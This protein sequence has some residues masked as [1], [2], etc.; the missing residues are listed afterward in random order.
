M[1][2]VEV[3]GVA[4]LCFQEP[5]AFKVQELQAPGWTKWSNITVDGRNPAP[6][7]MYKTL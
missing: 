6:P 4:D 5:K 1:A 3:V 7:A 2:V